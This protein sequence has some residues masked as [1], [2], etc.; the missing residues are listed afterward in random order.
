MVIHILCYRILLRYVLKYVY[1]KRLIYSLCIEVSGW[2]S[3]LG[4]SMMIVDTEGNYSL[5]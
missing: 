5:Q 3:V 2:I 1:K 4:E